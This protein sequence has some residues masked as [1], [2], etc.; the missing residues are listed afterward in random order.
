VLHGVNGFTDLVLLNL[1]ETYSEL[2]KT[3]GK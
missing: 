1:L 3:G 2:E